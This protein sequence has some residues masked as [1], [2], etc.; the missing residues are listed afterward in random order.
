MILK[1][2]LILTI[3]ALLIIPFLSQAASYDFYVDI[4]NTG[5][6]D[7][8]EANPYNT[9]TEAITAAEGNAE[10]NR[11]IY[12]ANGE[13]REQLNLPTKVELH[14]ESKSNT[15][16]YGKDTSGSHLKYTIKMNNR[17][18]IKNIQVK[19]GKT[20]VLVNNDD[21]ATI[22]KCKIK[23]FKKIG[24]EVEEADR[25]DSKLLKIEDSKIY[26]GKGKAM[27]IKSRKIEITDNEIYDN[28][29]EGI[30]LRSKMK[31]KIK[32]NDIHDNE[33]G[34]I[35]MELKSANLKITNNDIEDGGSSGINLQYRGKNKA[36][37]LTLKR[38]DIKDNRSWG[39]KCSTPVKGEPPVYYFK[40][41]TTLISNT[42][43]NNK[44]G[45]YSAM[46]NF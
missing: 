28:D 26:D 30:D 5:A 24:I 37:K 43:K 27:Y 35:E 15:V 38:N 17:T 36:G 44:K 6:E 7:G 25:K 40:D 32:N 22:D 31:G 16:V 34:G 41:A 21:K 12:I 45:A 4:T 42:I 11:K 8:T 13:Y 2:K 33:E 46:C 20:G 1:N 23:K 18:K 39:I 9:I 29:E 3:A 14:G 19:Y 10:D